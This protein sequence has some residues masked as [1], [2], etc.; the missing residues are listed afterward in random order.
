MINLTLRDIKNYIGSVEERGSP[1]Q[2]R[3]CLGDGYVWQECV[4]DVNLKF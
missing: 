2:S 3:L 4:K 1:L